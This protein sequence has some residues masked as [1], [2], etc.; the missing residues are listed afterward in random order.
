MPLRRLGEVR[1]AN[2]EAKPET[3]R[4]FTTRPIVL[5]RV[6]R[7]LAISVGASYEKS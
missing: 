7:R 3:T 2:G 4:T 1:T 5:P 6:G